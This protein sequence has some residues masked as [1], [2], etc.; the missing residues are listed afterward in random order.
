MDRTERRI[1]LV[2]GIAIIGFVMYLVA[3]NTPFA[4]PDLYQLVRIIISLGIGV[5]AGTVPGFLGISGNIAGLTLRAG[6][7]LAA[8]AITYFFAPGTIPALT[9]PPAGVVSIDPIRIV[10]F[11]TIA[12]PTESDGKRMSAALAVMMPVTARSMVQPSL[13]STIEHTQIR[14]SL[15]E[16]SYQLPWRDFVQMHEENFG[17]WIG[18]VG[19]AVPFSIASGAIVHQEILHSAPGI[20]SWDEF[21]RAIRTMKRDFIDVEITIRTDQG[22]VESKCVADMRERNIEIE[23]FIAKTQKNPGRITTTCIQKGA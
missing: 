18:K 5:V 11:R 15:D 2:V 13:G 19:D 20:L 22:A 3:R 23:E 4:T 9:P 14:F 10:D 16:K 8:F 17:K 1:G 7:G 6:G 12:P 21:L